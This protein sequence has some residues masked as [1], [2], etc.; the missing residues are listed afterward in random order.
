MNG[1]GHAAGILAR[2]S[3]GGELLGLDADPAAIERARP[4]AREAGAEDAFADVERMLREGGG[5]ARRRAAHARGGVD[6]MLAQLVEE[7]EEG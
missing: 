1:G 7:T 4:Y 3:P 2:S 6:A 5:A